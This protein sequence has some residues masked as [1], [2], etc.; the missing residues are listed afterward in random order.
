MRL[1]LLRRSTL[2]R[3]ERSTSNL[4]RISRCSALSRS[5]S[6]RTRLISGRSR[7]TVFRSIAGLQ[8]SSSLSDRVGFARHAVEK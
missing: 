5:A 4:A 3:S 1:V 7:S 2:R 8:S 6:A